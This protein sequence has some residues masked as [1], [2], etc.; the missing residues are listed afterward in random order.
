MGVRLNDLT[1]GDTWSFNV[2]A[3]DY[4]APTWTLTLYLVPRFT[5]PAQSPISL[6]S[7]ASGEE[8]SF[9]LAATVTATYVPGAYGFMTVASDGTQRFTLDG[10]AWSGEV[11][12]RPDPSAAAQGDD[13]RTQAQRALDDLRAALATYTATN[14][15]VAEYE[16]NGRRMKFRAGAEIETMIAFW[17]KER[18]AEVRADAVARGMADPRKVY[19][20][21]NR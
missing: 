16:I 12:L 1:V 19:L 4:P 14:G 11:T 6:T 2:T 5:T 17:Q 8:H 9:A 21:L 10:S 15:H 3:S 13:H 20:A 18:A 7:T